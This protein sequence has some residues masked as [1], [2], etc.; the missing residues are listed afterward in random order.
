[1]TLEDHVGDI[2]R[3]AR[4]MGGIPASESAAAAGISLAQLERFEDNG[5]PPEGIDW[6]RLAQRLDLEG[7]RLRRVAEGWLPEPIDT[8]RWR[9]FRQITT[10]GESMSVNCYLVWDET[11]RDAAL[12]DTGFDAEAIFALVD[13]HQLR[14]DHLF[15]THTHGD[16]VAAMQPIRE[17]YPGLRLHGS[18]ASIPQRHRNRDG[19]RIPLGQLVISHRET[20][21]H[22]TDGVTYLVDQFPGGAPP[23][24]VVG[25]AIFAGSI[26]GAQGKG[27]LARAKI[28]E[29]IL[30][31]P[32]DTLICPG[33]GPLT[34]VAEQ[35]TAN[36]FF[37]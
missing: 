17:R 20:P 21:G 27:D 25:D 34:T 16:H 35:L 37:A 23:L 5:T 28:R 29:N 36:P 22:A 32:G 4:L 30:S 9:H 2:L 6:N 1:M 3:K 13:R 10:R 33:H 8:S 12:F 26:G 11:T 15:I 14:L 18:G 31:L 7:T 24:A 19:E